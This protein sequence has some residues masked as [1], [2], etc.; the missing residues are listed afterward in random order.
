MIYQK[1]YD[2]E[3]F[4]QK[5]VFRE[6]QRCLTC[7]HER[8]K[9]TALLAK[10]GKFDCFSTTLL[11]SKFQQHD[12][13]RE[14][15]EAVAGS[16]GVTFFYQD[17]RVGWEQGVAASKQLQLYRQPYCGCIYSEKDR[18]YRSADKAAEDGLP[19]QA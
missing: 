8:L 11:Y 6:S 1:G 17:F 12:Q 2:L 3:A 14:I 19:F 18:F 15:G 9:A 4:I 7:Y 13:I 10:R 16:V 5:L